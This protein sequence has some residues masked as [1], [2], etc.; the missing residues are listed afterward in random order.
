MADLVKLSATEAISRIS[1]VMPLLG[2]ETVPLEKAGGRI[3][4]ED[5]RAAHNVPPFRASAMDG[6]ACRR[7]DIASGHALEVAGGG[8]AGSWPLPLRAGEARAISTGAPVPEGADRIVARERASIAAGRLTLR[9]TLGGDNIRLA[10]EDMMI[11]SVVARA[12]TW[13]GPDVVAA[14]AAS[15]CNAAIVRRWPAVVVLTTGTELTAG[16]DAGVP[17]SNGP[18]IAAQLSNLGLP[19]RRLATVKDQDDAL[20]HALGALGDA[21]LIISTGGVSAGDFDLVRGALE[22]VGARIVFHGIAMRPGKPL[23]FAILPDGRPFFGL[24]GNPVAALV[25]FRFFVF[26]AMRV[27]LGMSEETGMAIAP[28]APA[29]PGTTL[30]LRAR[31]RFDDAGRF[32]VDTDIDQR[33]HILSSVVAA[34]CWIRIT[35]EMTTLFEKD[36]GFRIR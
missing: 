10:G 36:P 12:G 8:A 16:G 27:M 11:G 21:D 2:S 7:S 29:R 33:S 18:M 6:F 26:A 23:L 3:L 25:G 19:D 35:G 32:A 5:V 1:A 9:D 4:F 14:L 15:G 13:L 20:D 24:P 34:D 28:V 17:D 30:Y 31:R 22:R